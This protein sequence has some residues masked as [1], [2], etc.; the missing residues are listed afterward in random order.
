M[1]SHLKCAKSTPY[2]ADN[3]YILE[4]M[5]IR[6]GEGERVMRACRQIALSTDL[7]RHHARANDASLATRG[8]IEC[9]LAASAIKH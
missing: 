2:A 6:N 3:I 5:S 9:A 8:P 1:S 4:G 7:I